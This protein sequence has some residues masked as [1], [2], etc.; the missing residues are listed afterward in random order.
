MAKLYLLRSLDIFISIILF[1]LIVVC[2]SL[3][4]QDKLQSQSSS[5]LATTLLLKGR[6]SNESRWLRKQQQQFQLASNNIAT[7]TIDQNTPTLIPVILNNNSTGLE[8]EKAE[9]EFVDPEKQKEYEELK[10][11]GNVTLLNEMIENEF[12]EKKTRNIQL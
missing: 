8:Q 6:N 7:T 2:V 10:N 4:A 9:W 1:Q 5:P 12:P 3:L 11:T